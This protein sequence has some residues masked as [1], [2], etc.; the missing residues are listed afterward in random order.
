MIQFEI[1]NKANKTTTAH[2][3]NIPVALT[4]AC[5]GGLFSNRKSRVASEVTEVT[6]ISTENY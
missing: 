4:D 3:V 5:S 1:K 2:P 6:N